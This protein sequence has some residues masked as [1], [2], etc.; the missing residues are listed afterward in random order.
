MIDCLKIYIEEVDLVNK[1]NQFIN[2]ISDFNNKHIIQCYSKNISNIPEGPCYISFMTP[3]G[4]INV[5]DESRCYVKSSFQVIFFNI[6]FRK[7]IMNFD[8]EKL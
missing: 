1:T 5:Q 8:C 2:D 7:F 4:F 6:V 3:T